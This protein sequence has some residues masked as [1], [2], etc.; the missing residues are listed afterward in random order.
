MHKVRFI[1]Q[2]RTPDGCTCWIYI[3]NEKFEKVFEEYKELYPNHFSPL[4]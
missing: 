1:R 4:A 2:E 3:R